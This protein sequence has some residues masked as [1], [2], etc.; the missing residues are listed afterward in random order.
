MLTKIEIR[1]YRVFERFALDFRDGLNV[2][3]GDNDCGKTTL[4]EA[5]AL[6]LTGRLADKPLQLVLSPHF[7]NRT[8]ATTYVA[9]IEQDEHPTP[10]EL[11][12]DLFLDDGDEYAPLR[13]SNNLLNED[14]PGLSVRACFD[15]RFAAEYETFINEN[16][17]SLKE[18]RYA[19]QCFATVWTMSEQRWLHPASGSVRRSPVT[20]RSP[21]SHGRQR[22]SCSDRFSKSARA[23]S[24]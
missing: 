20:A 17:L 4:L 1:N 12:I 5:V 3:V 19:P 7:F 8:A 16:A 9:G 18:T 23:S 24:Y 21:T 11:I 6:A 14:A 15:E 13:G 2:V 10:P 22:R